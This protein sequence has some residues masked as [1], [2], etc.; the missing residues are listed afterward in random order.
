MAILSLSVLSGK[1]G[2]LR[3]PVSKGHRR[4]LENLQVD[5]RGWKSTSG[6]DYL[7][8]I[9]YSW[10][11]KTKVTLKQGDQRNGH[12]FTDISLVNQLRKFATFLGTCLWERRKRPA[13]VDSSKTLLL[14]E[15]M[16]E[17]NKEDLVRKP[18][19]YALVPGSILFQGS[20]L[21]NNL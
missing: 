4:K 1:S 7:P 14:P 2:D 16:D 10:M 13:M 5:P 6:Y 8:C 15:D 9:F 17:C 11:V 21:S 12:S 18:Q 19:D 20:G 3:S